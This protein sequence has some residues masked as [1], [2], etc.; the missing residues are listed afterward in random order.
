M[1]SVSNHLNDKRLTQWHIEGIDESQKHAHA[2]ER[3]DDR[4][5]DLNDHKQ[6]DGLRHRARL[7]DDE[8]PVAIPAIRSHSRQRSNEQAGNLAR[9][10]NDSEQERRTSLSID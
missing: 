4:T 5:V 3:P 9:K 7:R 8:C 1:I 6:K 2:D 10:S